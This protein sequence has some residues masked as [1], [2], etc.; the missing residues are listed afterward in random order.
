M[1]R[2]QMQEVGRKI[3]RLMEQKGLSRQE[4]HSALLGQGKTIGEQTLYRLMAGKGNPTL[5]NLTIVAEFFGLRVWELLATE[6]EMRLMAAMRAALGGAP[7]NQT[8]GPDHG[9]PG[10]SGPGPKRKP[11]GH[12]R[13]G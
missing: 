1:D 13:A 10:K 11:G 8:Q 3:T 4:L 6:E 2:R 5:K 12:R 7:P 9:I